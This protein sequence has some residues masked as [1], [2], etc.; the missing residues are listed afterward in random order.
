MITHV[1]VGLLSF[2]VCVDFV[3]VL[4]DAVIVDKD[5]Y[6]YICLLHAKFGT[7]LPLDIR[8]SPTHPSSSPPNDWLYFRFSL[9]DDVVRHANVS[10]IIIFIIILYVIGEMINYI[11]IRFIVHSFHMC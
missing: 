3:F 1:T 2:Y 4:C 7:I 11:C 10:I 8:I 9:L 6:G 5:K